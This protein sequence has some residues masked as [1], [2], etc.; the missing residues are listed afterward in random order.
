MTEPRRAVLALDQGSH[1]SRACIVDTR[2]AI[3][4]EAHLPVRTWHGVAGQI[5]QDPDELVTSLQSVADRAI[6]IAR[7]A[8]PHAAELDIVAAGLATQ[9]STIVC[10]NARSDNVQLS[11]V[12]LSAA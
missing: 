10:F 6:G 2:G 5:E 12:R 4:A 8:E 1:A 9:R 3:L 7:S 11:G